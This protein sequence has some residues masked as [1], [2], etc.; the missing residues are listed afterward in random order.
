MGVPR[1]LVVSL[2]AWLAA[3]HR[4][5]AAHERPP[6][7]DELVA[8]PAGEVT[9][10]EGTRS[11]ASFWLAATPTTSEDFAAYARARHVV[12]DAERLGEGA[13][14]DLAAG[15][16]VARDGVDHRRPRG[17]EPARPRDPVT[18]VSFDDATRYCVAIGGRLPTEV[19]WEH[20]ARN[21]RDDR[22]AF[23]WGDD[24]DD[25]AHP[26]RANVWQG[27][28]PR[29]N[30][31]VDGHLFV[32]PV[33][34]FPATALGL[35]DMVGNVWQ[36]VD[37]WFAEGQR[38]MRGGSHLCDRQQCHGYRI[39]ARQGATPDSS[40][41]HVGFRCAFDAPRASRTE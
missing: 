3:C 16:I 11:V 1:G 36:W 37:G 19:E 29:V 4:A 20:A 24:E 15:R 9:T 10:S 32:S 27:S 5:D 21:A 34:A 14:F 22:T 41:A 33:R 2:V 7:S 6:T 13:V 38:V 25:A 28:F 40:F 39:D 31:L 8:V 23:P 26:P 18:Q 30:T 17:D 12:T 35:Y